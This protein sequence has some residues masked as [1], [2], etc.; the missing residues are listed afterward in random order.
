VQSQSAPDTEQCLYGGGT[1]LSGAT[2]RQSL[3][4]STLPNPNGWVMWLAHRTVSGGAPDC[5]VRSSTAALPNG[6]LVVEG[7]KYP[8]PPPFQGPKILSITFITIA[9]AFTPRH[10][11]KYQSLSKSQIQLKHLVTCE[12]EILC[13]FE[14][15]PLGLPSSFLISFLK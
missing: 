15:L 12:R 11:S 13:S 7:Y 9:L 2:R 6:L 4:R 3:Q 14:L 5:P 10:N 8:Q 1:G